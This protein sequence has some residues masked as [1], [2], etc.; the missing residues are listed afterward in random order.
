MQRE[1]WNRIQELLKGGHGVTVA[2]PFADGVW[3]T[4]IYPNEGNG[5]FSHNYI[6]ADSPDINESIHLAGHKFNEQI[7]KKIIRRATSDAERNPVK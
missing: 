7:V 5:S 4:T 1:A 2:Q 6:H 3:K